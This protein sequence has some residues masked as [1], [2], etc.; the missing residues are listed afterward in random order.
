M[1][2][3][4]CPFK[5]APSSRPRAT[6]KSQTPNSNLRSRTGSKSQGTEQVRQVMECASPLALFVRTASAWPQLLHAQPCKAPKSKAPEDWR[7][8]K[9]GGSL[10]ARTRRRTGAW[11]SDLP[12]SLELDVWS[13][14]RRLATSKALIIM[15]CLLTPPRS[16]PAFCGFYVAKAD[17]KLFNKASQVVLVRHEDK[18]MLT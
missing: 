12:W 3:N 6:E 4:R 9:P 14:L 13:L 10:V 11:N 18:T 8:P 2:M 7:T 16:A 17:T 5:K 15:A 1:F